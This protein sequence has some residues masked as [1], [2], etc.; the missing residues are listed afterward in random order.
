MHL[1]LVCVAIVT[2]ASCVFSHLRPLK[3]LR[4]LQNPFAAAHPAVSQTSAASLSHTHTHI[5]TI[6][7]SLRIT[8][9]QTIVSVLCRHITAAPVSHR[10]LKRG[11]EVTCRSV[12]SR[13]CL[14][15]GFSTFSTSIYSD[16]RCLFCATNSGCL[17]VFVCLSLLAPLGYFSKSPWHNNITEYKQNTV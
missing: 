14:N 2:L 4:E 9:V 7:L 5:L 17:F 10:V 6:N 12:G 15:Q 11:H 8:G 3:R 1:V 16:V 13:L